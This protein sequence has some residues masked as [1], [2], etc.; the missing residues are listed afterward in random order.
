MRVQELGTSTPIAS[1]QFMINRDD[2]GNTRDSVVDCFPDTNP[3]YPA[4]C[5]WASV[6]S[7]NGGTQQGLVTQGDETHLNETIGINL[8]DGKYV[9]SVIAAGH[10]IDGEHFSV[11]LPDT[12]LVTVQMYAMPLPLSTIRVRVFE[13]IAGTNGELD[14]PGEQGLAGFRALVEDVAGEVTTDWYGNPLCTEYALDSLGNPD[15]EQPIPG[16]GGVCLSDSNGDLVIPNLGPGRYE[17]SAI[18]PNGQTWYRT[19][20]LE[21]GPG[22]D[23][24]PQENNSGYETEIIIGGEAQPEI[25]MGF[26]KPTSCTTNPLAPVSCPTATGGI[27][28]TVWSVKTYFPPVGGLFFGGNGGSSTNGVALDKRVANPLVALGA[29]QGG[30]QTVWMGRGNTNGTFTI[31]NVPNGN[32][33]LTVWDTNQLQLLDFKQV[34]VTGGQVTNAGDIMV[35]HWFGIIE[36][37]IFVDTNENGIKDAGEFGIPN[38]ALTLRKRDNALVDQFDRFATTNNS[39]YY[40]F[41]RVY[42]YLQWTVLEAYNDRYFTTGYTFKTD[43]QPTSTTVLGGGVDVS[44]FVGFGL[45]TRVDWGVKPYA[46]GTNGGIAGTVSY[47]VTRNELDPR[48]AAIEDYQPG[49]PDLEMRLYAAKKDASGAFEFEADG[50]YK[51]GPLLNT[52]TTETWQRP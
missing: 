48:L 7:I 52:Y 51:K 30:D 38:Y 32:Y 37:Y 17:V 27:T 5:N 14:I 18:P 8:P 19:T 44:V 6:H 42:P 40:T 15:P 39:G 35:A 10:K 23:V 29:L 12:G 36:G 47:E 43:N 31:Q 25:P 11:P 49:I 1:Y 33:V 28:G 24:W 26:V 16:T 20:T 3:D 41:R 21:G 46:A 4:G 50:S 45:T 34:T 2:S 13:D 22:W 9:I